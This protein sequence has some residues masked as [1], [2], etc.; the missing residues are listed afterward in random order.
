MR[1]FNFVPFHASHGLL[2]FFE[3]RIHRGETGGKRLFLGIEGRM[4][5]MYVYALCHQSFVFRDTLRYEI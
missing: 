5:S 2:K 4:R 1:H 3:E